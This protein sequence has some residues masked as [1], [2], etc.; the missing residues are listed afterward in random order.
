[1][2]S[3][4]PSFLNFAERLRVAEEQWAYLE[5]QLL[6]NLRVAMPGVIKTFDAAKQTATVQPTIRENLN[7]NLQPTPIEIPVLQDVPIVMLR[8]GGVALT[9]P[10]TEGDECL[11]VFADM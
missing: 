8:A 2:G 3:S 1:M 7:V 5:W 11:L 4:P 10:V 6:C 9:M